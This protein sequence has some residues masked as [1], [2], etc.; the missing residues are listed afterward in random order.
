MQKPLNRWRSR[1]NSYCG[2]DKRAMWQANRIGTAE[3]CNAH[4]KTLARKKLSEISSS[5]ERLGEQVSVT[6]NRLS[7]Y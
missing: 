5:C 3:K 4:V 6:I 2:R 1:T 7:E